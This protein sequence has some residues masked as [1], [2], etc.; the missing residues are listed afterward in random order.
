MLGLKRMDFIIIAVLILLA[1]ILYIIFYIYGKNMTDDVSAEILINGQTIKTVSLNEDR[2]FTIDELPDVKFEI[3]DK[4]IRFLESDCPDKICVN[5]G[6][7]GADTIEKIAVCLPN[8]ASIH[9]I[10]SDKNT[11]SPDAIT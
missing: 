2:I 10:S 6:F 1:I 3:K 8:S 11:N 4:K 9:I 7:I 5:T